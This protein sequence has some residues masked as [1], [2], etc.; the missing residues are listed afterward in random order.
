[1]SAYSLPPDLE[2]LLRTALDAITFRRGLSSYQGLQQVEDPEI[3]V[4][5][6]G[7]IHLPLS[8]EQGWELLSKAQWASL[9]NDETIADTTSQNGWELN[10]ILHMSPNDKARKGDF[11]ITAGAQWDKLLRK[12]LRVV[13][14]ELGIVRPIQAYLRKMLLYE[15]YVTLKAHGETENIP[16]VIGTLAIHLPHSC[17][18]GDVVVRDLNQ[19]MVWNTSRHAMSFAFWHN[20]ATYEIRPDGPGYRWVLIYSLAATFSPG[21]SLGGVSQQENKLLHDILELWARGRRADDPRVFYHALG[22][23]YAQG[24]LSL[25]D[26]KLRDRAC[27]EQLLDASRDRGF[28]IFL[29][30]LERKDVDDTTEDNDYGDDYYHYRN[31]YGLDEDDDEYPYATARGTRSRLRAKTVYDLSGNEI[32]SS[33]TIEDRDILQDDPFEDRDRKDCN[34]N[35]SRHP[36]EAET[37][38]RISALVIVPPKGIVPF[39]TSGS[40]QSSH[41]SK[42]GLCRA[43]NYLVTRCRSSDNESTLQILLDLLQETS[44]SRQVR[45]LTDMALLENLYQLAMTCKG[46]ELIIWITGQSISL[47]FPLSV[48]SWSAKQFDLSAISFERLSTGFSHVIETRKW[49]SSQYQAILALHEDI[50]PNDELLELIRNTACKAVCQWESSCSYEDGLALFDLILYLPDHVELMKSSI[51]PRLLETPRPITAIMLGFTHRWRE[52][53]RRKKMLSDEVKLIYEHLVR[54]TIRVM[55]VSALGPREKITEQGYGNQGIGTIMSPSAEVTYQMLHPFVL[56]L[57]QP[58][59]EEQRNIFMEKI[60]AEA[61][62]IKPENFKDLWIPLLQDLLFACRKLDISLDAPNWQR[63][64]QGVLQAFLFQCVGRI[65]LKANL[66]LGRVSCPCQTCRLLNQFL[67]DPTKMV[68]RLYT[69]PAQ[70]SHVEGKLSS[71]RINCRLERDGHSVII[72]K[73]GSEDGAQERRREEQKLD[74]AKHLFGFDQQKLRTVLADKYEAIMTMKVLEPPDNAPTALPS[75]AMQMRRAP[76][77]VSANPAQEMARL[78]AEM[79]SLVNS[80]PSSAPTQATKNITTWNPQNTSAMPAQMSYETTAAFSPHPFAPPH[81]A[82]PGGSR[83]GLPTTNSSTPSSGIVYN[84]TNPTPPQSAWQAPPV[85]APYILKSSFTPSYSSAVTRPISHPSR[86]P[87]S[88]MIPNPV[89]GAKRKIVECIDLT[90]D[91]D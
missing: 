30:T 25:A 1:M 12:I 46:W 80:T 13:S 63:F 77:P 66:I 10:P 59:L 27:A 88:M 89:A 48:L 56:S 51:I 9:S 24:N 70:R 22:Y 53:I 87:P 91:D 72:F 20:D 67:V 35:T 18:G 82:L 78:E 71:F 85:P 73:Q 49:L 79:N 52:S 37:L 74:A 83:V 55:S 45:Y 41:D 44:K 36:P 14:E 64:Y 90:L 84:Y 65:F 21:K 40:P 19:E 32:L 23:K 7:K 43:L 17:G 50:N 34:G 29:A 38:N 28:E 39:F 81:T 3:V 58:G 5:D 2:V 86:P 4:E 33:I 54:A 8:E 15:E 31:C 62:T 76:A 42:P 60:N 68:M 47:P 69:T 26:L 75:S 57:F 6:V 16:N 11:T 61:K